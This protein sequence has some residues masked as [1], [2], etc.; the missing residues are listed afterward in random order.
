V[1]LQAANFKGLQPT[2]N[3]F[4][5]IQNVTFLIRFTWITSFQ[6]T[7]DVSNN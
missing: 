5:M 3:V 7:R 6:S 2:F 1:K 4:Q